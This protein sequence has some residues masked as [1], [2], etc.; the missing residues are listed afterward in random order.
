MMQPVPEGYDP[1][2]FV[3]FMD[4]GEY[5]SEKIYAENDI[6]HRNNTAWRCL[7]DGTIG[8]EPEEGENWTVF[9]ASESDSSGITTT[10]TQGIVGEKGSK[11]SN[12]DLIDAIADRVINKLM[13]KSMMSG[14]QVD[15]ENKVPTSALA[16]AMQQ[17]IDGLNENLF[18]ANINITFDME[19]IS[20]P[21]AVC[22]K[23][24]RVCTITCAFYPSRSGTPIVL[25]VMDVHSPYKL[26]FP[27]MCYDKN[28]SYG[29]AE[30]DGTINI[31][32]T[33]DMVGEMCVINAAFIID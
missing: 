1:L 15:D 25:G 20:A 7:I 26:Y 32:I 8:I 30:T 3:G 22:R 10:D 23:S 21:Y 29:S 31:N 18:T 27:V 14:V 28:I 9:I 16:Y 33:N 24:G 5:S 6:V 19:N 17:S 12:Q 13:E 4:C 11:V 2:N